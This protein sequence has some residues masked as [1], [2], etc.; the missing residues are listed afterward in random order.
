MTKDDIHIDTRP[1]IKMVEDRENERI[2]M[3]HSIIYGTD[4]VAFAATHMQPAVG[5]VGSG[6]VLLLMEQDCR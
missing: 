1:L 4:Y 5:G 6:Y 2:L 3:Q